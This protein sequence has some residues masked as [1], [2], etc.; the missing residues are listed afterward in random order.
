MSGLPVLA[1]GRDRRWAVHL[2]RVL[3]PRGEL[4]WCGVFTVETLPSPTG[5][6]AIWLLDGDDL[7]T[8]R[9]PVPDSQSSRIYCYRHPD[10]GS[11]RSCARLGASGC[12]E[13]L[14]SPDVLLR[15]LRAVESGLFAVDSA[16]LTRALAA[17][18]RAPAPV[19]NLGHLTERQREIVHWA[20]MGMSNKQIGRRL[21]ISPETVKSHLHQVFEREGI[22]G[23]VALLA[24]HRPDGRK[25]PVGETVVQD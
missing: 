3:A 16:L 24:L 20:A 7:R 22:S 9:L 13:K 21:G 25:P 6:P 8:A 18:R 19:N 10:V 2:Q 5:R 4:D 12:L 11:L 14:A 17:E 1:F 23:R 15:A